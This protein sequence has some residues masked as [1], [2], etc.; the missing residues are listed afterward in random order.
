MM[1]FL[2]FLLTN[3]QVLSRND[4]HDSWRLKEA[5]EL[6]T[7]IKSRF[8]RLQNPEKCDEADIFQC[9][10]QQTKNQKEGFGNLIFM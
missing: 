9:Y 5:E 3:L 2:R 10:I 6:R 8:E 7:K 4:G 1:L